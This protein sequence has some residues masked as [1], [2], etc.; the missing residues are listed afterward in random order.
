MTPPIGHY[1]TSIASGDAD[2]G[3]SSEWTME[4]DKLSNVEKQLRQSSPC[5]QY[6]IMDLHLRLHSIVKEPHKDSN[7]LPLVTYSNTKN[8]ELFTSFM[9]KNVFLAA[10]IMRYGGYDPDHLLWKETSSYSEFF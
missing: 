1:S 3:A 7:G 2:A 5:E 4:Y 10:K 8:G 9:I 6:N